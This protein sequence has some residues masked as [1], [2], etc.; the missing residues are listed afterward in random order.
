MKMAYVCS[1]RGI[2]VFGSKGCSLHVQEASLAFSQ[3]AV[4]VNMFAASLG[5]ECPESLPI[6]H[7]HKIKHARIKERAAREQSD[8]ADNQT[9]IK[10]LLEHGPFNFVYERYSLWS[11]AGM[12]YAREI[13]VPG[14]LEVNA[15]L[16]EEQKRYR[17]L[18]DENAA[19]AITRQCFSAATHILAVSKEVAQYLEQYPQAKGKIHVLPNGVNVDRFIPRAIG[20]RNENLTIGF[21][22][23]LKPWHGVEGLIESFA[24]L[25]AQYANIRLLILGD[26]PQRRALEQQVKTLHIEHKVKMTGAISPQLVPEYMATIDIGVAPYPSGLDFY[27][28]PLKVYEYMA[29]G[30]PIVASQTGQIEELIEHGVNGVLYPA[31]DIHALTKA[32]E[33]L[34]LEPV[35]AQS[36][37]K[38]A[39]QEAEQYHS[40]VRRMSDVLGLVMSHE[41][42][43]YGSS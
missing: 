35:M 5:N 16:I 36:L 6:T 29:A 43:G 7:V 23:S 22:G 1:D 12:T 26:G 25:Q 34:I 41:G 9:T 27:F 10:R 32:I 4:E 42:G 31:G 21:I 14:V 15:P 28:S 33:Q 40:W 30:L 8:I 2:P 13:G 24:Q 17:G 39:R 11:H 20:V 18:I 38:R 3:L 19:Q 37:G